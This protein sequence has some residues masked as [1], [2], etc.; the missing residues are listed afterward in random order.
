MWNEI[1][2][3][4]CNF[5]ENSTLKVLKMPKFSLW[6][7]D[8]IHKKIKF[9]N[10]GGENLQF[11]S[12]WRPLILFLRKFHILKR[13]IFKITK[14]WNSGNCILACP[15]L[16]TMLKTEIFIFCQSHL[17]NLHTTKIKIIFFLLVYNVTF[18]CWFFCVQNDQYS[19]CLRENPSA[20]II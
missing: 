12:F 17:F 10:L 14:F 20:R 9:G 8:F 1:W 5:G 4:N 13:K 19:T 7:L 18:T 3:W 15:G 11:E 2:Q 6:H 16:Y